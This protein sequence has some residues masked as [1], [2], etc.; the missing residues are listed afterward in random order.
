ML[1]LAELGKFVGGKVA[2]A[3]IFVAMAGG[4]LWCYQHPEALQAGWHV[5]KM[6]LLWIVVA[7][8]LPW[9]SYLFI[10]PLMARQARMQ[11]AQS[12]G[13]TGVAVITAYSAADIAFALYLAGGGIVGSFSWFVVFLGFAAAAA[14]NFV[15][16]ESLA[17]QADA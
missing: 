6:S 1:I 8:A 11:S 15:I 2:T 13:A 12:A 7:A 9:S 4:G 17:R 16:C 10:Q 14:Y 5:V 3:L